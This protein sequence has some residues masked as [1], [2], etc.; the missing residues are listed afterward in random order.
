MVILKRFD[1]FFPTLWADNLLIKLIVAH[2][3][4]FRPFTTTSF[5]VSRRFSLVNH[6]H[7]NLFIRWLR[8]NQFGKLSP[9]VLPARILH[10]RFFVIGRVN[11]VSILLEALDPLEL[12]RVFLAVLVH[13]VIEPFLFISILFLFSLNLQLNHFLLNKLH[14]LLERRFRI[15]LWQ[16]RAITGFLTLVTI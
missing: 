2:E 4:G 11:I 5:V 1:K 3:V 7:F 16:L 6:L 12:H 15:A 14:F 10:S 13:Q 8:D 9:T